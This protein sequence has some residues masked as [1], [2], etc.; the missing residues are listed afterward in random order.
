[1]AADCTRTVQAIGAMDTA[2]CIGIGLALGIAFGVA[3]QSYVL[4][5]VVGVAAGALICV[6]TRHRQRS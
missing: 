4:G 6:F 1:M 5:I 2:K 3:L